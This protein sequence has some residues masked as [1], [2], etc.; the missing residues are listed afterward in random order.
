MRTSPHVQSLTSSQ[1]T[2]MSQSP[3]IHALR[4][5]RRELFE[6]RFD[7]PLEVVNNAGSLDSLHYYIWSEHLFLDDFV[8]DSA[9]IPRKN[10][11]A[12]GIQY[13]P[14]FVAWWSLLNLER[15][16]RHD[17]KSH[18]QNFLVQVDWLKTNAVHRADG[19]VVW[20]C[21]FDW[22]EGF[23][24]LRSP[25][26]SAMYQG[27]IISA[28]VRGYRLTGDQQLLDLCKGATLVFHQ[29]IEEGGVKTSVNGE[30]LY[31][32]YPGYPLARVLDGFLFSL[33]GL[34]DFAVQSKTVEARKLFDEGIEG[35]KQMLEFWDYRN[36]WSW[37]G[38]K[39]YLSPP[40]YHKLNYSLL[41]ILGKLTGE[42]KLLRYAGLWGG[43]SRSFAK[44]LEIYFVFAITKNLARLRLPRN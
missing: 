41:S 7:Y 31:E 26:I 10:Y 43:T 9:G 39:A 23:C 28:L 30:S 29:T 40:H 25:W 38:N 4:A 17:D 34:Y 16:L 21:Y 32:E 15:Y 36:K 35:L 13:N 24:R 1:P 42:E 19:A 33:L 20:P 6:F 14:L 44:S 37:Y 27:V 8:F 18:L 3:F 22:Q 5:L 11:R 2:I 12:Q